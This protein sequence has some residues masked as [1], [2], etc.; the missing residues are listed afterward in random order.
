MGYLLVKA[1]RV[2]REKTTD[3]QNVSDN[4]L[5]HSVILSTRHH[6]RPWSGQTKL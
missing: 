1:T 6:M 5:S 3:M 4:L 2:C